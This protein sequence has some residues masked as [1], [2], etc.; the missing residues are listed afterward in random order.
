MYIFIIFPFLF[1]I[2]SIFRSKF[3]MYEFC[4]RIN[5]AFRAINALF[6]QSTSTLFPISFLFCNAFYINL[7]E[8]KRHTAKKSHKSAFRCFKNNLYSFIAV[9][10][11][12]NPDLDAFRLYDRVRNQSLILHSSFAQGI[13]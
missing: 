12:N 10:S 1:I 6:M 3:I 7:G 2:I 11:G 13:I 9:A 5:N 8:T 4:K